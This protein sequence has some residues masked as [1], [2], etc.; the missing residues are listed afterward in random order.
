MTTYPGIAAVEQATALTVAAIHHEM[1]AAAHEFATRLRRIH[2]EATC[3]RLWSSDQG[4]WLD[5]GDWASGHD[6][7]QQWHQT[8]DEPLSIL[9]THLYEAHISATPDTSAY[10]VPGLWC[11]DA[12]R[13]EYHLDLLR[14]LDIQLDPLAEVLVARVS[15][16]AVSLAVAG[17]RIPTVVE[18]E[19]NIVETWDPLEWDEVRDECA[20][21]ASAAM[22]PTVLEVFNGPG[23]TLSYVEDH[24]VLR[25][26]RG[27]GVQVNGPRP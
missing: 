15:G 23:G 17:C 2:P 4:D 16:V 10:P 14:T 12:R 22:R 9:A 18:R 7:P 13:G 19:V 24:T 27:V 26:I 6:Q 25:Q 5:L 11:V 3:A 20:A 21:R 1:R 8:D